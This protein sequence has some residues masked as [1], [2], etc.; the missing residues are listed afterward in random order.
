MSTNPPSTAPMFAAGHLDQETHLGTHPGLTMFRSGRSAQV[1]YTA[2]SAGLHASAGLDVIVIAAADDLLHDELIPALRSAAKAV[3][4][5]DNRVHLIVDERLAARGRNASRYIHEASARIVDA[6]AEL[7]GETAPTLL[8]PLSHLVHDDHLVAVLHRLLDPAH[9]SGADSALT[10]LGE[11]GR[12]S[13]LLP[14]SP[15]RRVV[16]TR[17]S[18]AATPVL[19]DAQA[20]LILTSVV[21]GHDPS[22]QDFRAVKHRG[23]T[24]NDLGWVS[25]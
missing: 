6:A 14:V 10:K 19:L 20:D 17:D 13:R 21:R 22:Q 4:D 2:M 12:P 18:A 23:F 3:P 8:L 7:T 5:M 9:P 15:R 24:P 25:L 11:L 16:A 1:S